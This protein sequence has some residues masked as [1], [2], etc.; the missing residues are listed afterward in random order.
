[1]EVKQTKVQIKPMGLSGCKSRASMQN[2]FS[3][4]T[5]FDSL[6]RVVKMVQT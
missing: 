3:D 5:L 4:N 1:M 2:I 6:G